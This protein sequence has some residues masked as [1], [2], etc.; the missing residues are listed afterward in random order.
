M[1]T[2]VLSVALLSLALSAASLS[3]A[4]DPAPN[5]KKSTIIYR[6]AKPGQVW[7]GWNDDSHA[8]THPEKTPAA[9]EQ[10]E[11]VDQVGAAP[12]TFSGKV[13][14]DGPMTG[15]EVGLVSLVNIHWNVP[16]AYQWEP[17]AADGFFNLTDKNHL[18]AS[19]ALALRGPNTAWCFLHYNFSPQQ[20]AK[21]IV[22]TAVPSKKVRLTASA[23]DMVDLDKVAFE[24]FDAG[25]VTDAEGRGLYLQQYG[26]LKTGDQKYLDVML[27]VGEIAIYVHRGGFADY[28]QI[29]DTTKANHIHFVL[30]KAGRMKITVLDADGKP[31]PNWAV[32]WNNPE[33]Y[34]SFWEVKT[35]AAG[36]TTPD[37]LVPG[38]FDVTVSGFEK[39]KVEVKE[40]MVTEI[41][42]QDG[43]PPTEPVFSKV[44]PKPP[45]PAPAPAAK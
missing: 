28:Y 24:P 1:K 14:V 37:H 17:V 45:T 6:A 22:L 43:K 41:T 12:R 11:V 13:V 35:N 20:G 26:Y 38:T 9:F 4:A 16:D 19:K 32:N 34:L 15:V 18:D 44:L 3:H 21:D 27:P 42:Y 40:D 2:C 8:I 36:V 23:A 39:N 7:E 30:R 25:N 10:F 29:V 33:A 5:D 31:K